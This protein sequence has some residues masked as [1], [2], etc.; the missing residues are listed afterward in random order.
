MA[1]KFA[2]ITN[3][4]IREEVIGKGTKLGVEVGLEIPLSCFFF[5][6]EKQEL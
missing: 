6:M 4:Q 5:F 1:S 2:Q 3:Y